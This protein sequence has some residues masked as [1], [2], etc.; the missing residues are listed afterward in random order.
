[1]TGGIFRTSVSASAS[2]RGSGPSRSKPQRIL[3]LSPLSFNRTVHTILYSSTPRI[4]RHASWVVYHL[5]TARAKAQGRSLRVPSAWQP[6][7]Y[8]CGN[9]RSG[10]SSSVP[11]CF[12]GHYGKGSLN[13]ATV[14]DSKE[15]E[16]LQ[17]GVPR[18]P[19]LPWTFQ[20][21]HPHVRLSDAPTQLLTIPSQRPH[22]LATYSKL[23]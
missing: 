10:M 2:R 17:P 11:H 16:Y 3:K 8:G 5:T 4:S 13:M 15:P 6:L 7:F 1:M 21:I 9:H 18:D 19:H 22:T 20:D 12:V 14:R 23:G